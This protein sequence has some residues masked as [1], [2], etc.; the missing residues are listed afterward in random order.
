M[1]GVPRTVRIARAV[2][3]WL[4]VLVP[5]A[6]RH[7]YREEMIATFETASAEASARGRTAVCVL[8]AREIKDLAT[9]RVANRPAGVVMP[10]PASSG[11][12]ARAPAHEWMDLS[13]WLQSWR[14]LRRRP[15]FL[16]AAVLTLGLGGGIT[17][18]VFALVNTVLV[19]PLPFPNGDDLVMVYE[20]SPSGRERTSLLAPGRLEEWNRQNQTFVAI[21]GSYSENV[22]DT[23]ATE[24]ERLDGRRVAPRFFAVFGMR[25]LVGR[26]FV[27]EEE[28]ANGP[29]AAMISERFWTRRFARD[30]SA[31][32][33]ALVIGGR[34][35]EIVGVMP[36]AFT[37][38]A[39]ASATTD[40]WLPAQFSAFMMR[41]R[42]ARFLTAVGRLR[43]GVTVQA[44]ARDLAGVQA[45][46]GRQFPETDAGWS[47][48]TRPMKDARIGASRKGLV[49]VLGAVLTLWLIAVANI[50]GLTLVQVHRRARELAIRAA[51]GASRARV[52]ST[53]IRE[54]LL[55]A[56]IGGAVAMALAVWLVAAMPAVL[57]RTPRINELALDW[58][59]VGVGA[60]TS[61]FAACVFSLVPALAG[62]RLGL[63]RVIAG[64][65]GMAG[66]SRGVAGGRHQLQKVLVV[67]QVALSVLL[68][69]SAT[70]LIRSY[71]N[72]ANVE[73]GLDATNAVTFHVGA[74]WDEDRSRIRL[75]Q[76]Q[77]IVNLQQL[78]HVQAA[79][80]TNFL[81]ATGATLRYAVTV[82]GLTGP[83]ADGTMTVG[84]R[85]ISGG[86]LRAIR[87][88]LLAGAWCPD[89][90]TDPKGPLSAMV[91]QRFVDLFA[92]GQTLIG[93]QFHIAQTNPPFTIAGIIG[94]I[95]EDG[96]GT[97]AAPYAYTCVPGGAWPDPE[98]VVRTVDA[99]A[100]ATD[101]RRI[102]HELD[103]ARAIFGLRPV[104]DVLDAALDQPRLDAAML[105]FFAG[106]AVTLAA[107]GLY[108]L[109]MLVVSERAR[110]MAVRLAIGAA[111]R[112]VIGLVMSGAG[113]LLAGG[114]VLGIVLT[115]AADRVL[116]GV[117]FGVSPL[118]IRAL[119]AAAVT[120]AIVSLVAV[121][122]PALKAA[123]IAPIEALRGD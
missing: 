78:P 80:M 89:P 81:P 116:R 1:S 87:A 4:L 33:R 11:S 19:K 101:L 82:D 54:G 48:E 56:F 68:V 99:R 86:Y 12:S 5:R 15:A 20:S 104:Q 115:A 61:V 90:T 22:T 107:I 74:R 92:P 105:G 114:I 45:E 120:L 23:S 50:A 31:V 75:L 85:M 44:G 113:R 110:E 14:S 52:V 53:V 59:I 16:A 63:T 42:N 32:G 2:H 8:L 35:Y 77:L 9:A 10:G 55:I 25:P 27:D 71:Y 49:L 46:L 122:G 119:A 102:V 121:A 69:G 37:P 47:S 43:P 95:A 76:Q 38:G 118:D 66:G 88:P 41:Q 58:W 57:S 83:N 79:G 91:N 65:A 67:A 109:F 72:L 6:V 18:A 7:T 100:F 108:S 94:N 3:R 51:L 64:M 98:Y 70:L 36:G 28:Q 26:A 40:V 24:P 96:H 17:I 84:T 123:R 112:Q 62:T 111:P 34:S 29:G 97:S 21:S 39:F 13:N 106:A 73:T 103:P 93:R 30:P 60:L 117:V